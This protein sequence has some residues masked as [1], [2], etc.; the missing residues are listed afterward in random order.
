MQTD[1]FLTVLSILWVANINYS[2]PSIL[3]WVGL[4]VI[5]VWLVTA[6]V[7]RVKK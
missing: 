6:I 4:A 7:S 2:K 5:I 3:D 1:T